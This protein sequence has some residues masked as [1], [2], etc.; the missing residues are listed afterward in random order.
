MDALREVHAQNEEKR[1]A[2]RRKHTDVYEEFEK[3]HAELDVLSA[4]LSSLTQKEVALDANF[5]RYG[6][7][8]HI[9]KCFQCGHRS[10][11]VISYLLRYKGSRLLGKLNYVRTRER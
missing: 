4:E 8:A 10:G 7:S 6:Y 5:S 3:V 1:N 2:L 9:R 11:T